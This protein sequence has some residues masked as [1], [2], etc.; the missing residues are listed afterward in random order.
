MWKLSKR[1]IKRGAKQHNKLVAVSSDYMEY[2]HEEKKGQAFLTPSLLFFIS[3]EWVVHAYGIVVQ[4]PL[5]PSRP[6]ICCTIFLFTVDF[7]LLSP[8]IIED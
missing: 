3:I 1:N 6:F 8:F 4:P 2:I 7:F 5:S